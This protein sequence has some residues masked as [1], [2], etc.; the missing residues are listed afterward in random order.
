MR[1][2]I[3]APLRRCAL[4]SS[5]SRII[6]TVCFTFIT[7]LTIACACYKLCFVPLYQLV[8]GE[9]ANNLFEFRLAQRRHPRPYSRTRLSAA[10]TSS[11]D[12]YW[13]SMPRAPTARPPIRAP[14]SLPPPCYMRPGEARS[15]S[16]RCVGCSP[17]PPKRLLNYKKRLAC[18]QPPSFSP[19]SPR[20]L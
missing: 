6:Q 4:F 8:L 17:L 20:R 9:L 3:C 10:E 13:R 16:G 18:R 15:P 19:H 12:H 5:T 14:N 2:R 1:L 7:G 11:V